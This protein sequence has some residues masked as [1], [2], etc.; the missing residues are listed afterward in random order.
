MLPHTT[1]STVARQVWVF[2]GYC[3]CAAVLTSPVVFHLTTQI[4]IAHKI[5][6]WV[7]GDGDPRHSLWMLWFTK[8][9]VFELD[10]FPLFIDALFYPRGADLRYLSLIILPLLLSLPLVRL[11]GLIAAYNRLTLLSLASVGYASLLLVNYPRKDGW[12]AC[13]SG[14]IMAH[15]G[16]PE[17]IQDG[18]PQ[19][20]RYERERELTA[21]VSPYI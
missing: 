19:S 5:P 21:L 2:G 12:A 14:L 10:R 6:G 20:R 17:R 9:S 13:V 4:S 18:W 15:L 8:H 3:V 11:V 16:Y 7:P 1:P